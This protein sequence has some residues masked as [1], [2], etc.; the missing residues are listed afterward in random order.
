MSWRARLN[1]AHEIVTGARGVQQARVEYARQA[2]A[3]MNM[4]PASLTT[5]LHFSVSRGGTADR[6]MPFSP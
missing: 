1:L 6:D 2:T 3:F 4:Q 5:G